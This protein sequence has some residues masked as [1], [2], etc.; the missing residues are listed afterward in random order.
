M[1]FQGHP[2]HSDLMKCRF[3]EPDG[4]LYTLSVFTLSNKIYLRFQ[5]TYLYGDNGLEFGSGVNMSR[6]DW[7]SLKNIWPQIM[8]CWRFK[9]QRT[10]TIS[11]SHMSSLIVY[12]TRRSNGSPKIIFMSKILVNGNFLDGTLAIYAFTASKCSKAFDLAQETISRYC[13]DHPDLN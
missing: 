5:R 12:V 6:E 13:H 4:R 10:F 11:S 8:F 2:R 9:I 3:Y 7:E 1:F